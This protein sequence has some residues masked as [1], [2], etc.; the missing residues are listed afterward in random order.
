MN[1]NE[2]ICSGCGLVEDYTI[3]QKGHQR[4]VTCNGCNKFLGNKPKDSYDVKSIRMP[5][6]KYKDQI[7]AQ[8]NDV[9]YFRWVL[10]N[11]PNLKG[12]LLAAIK[13][14]VQ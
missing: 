2:V 12:G 14:K 13:W 9:E 3:T 7:I 1:W 6:G 11:I 5:F 8:V 4:V 10:K